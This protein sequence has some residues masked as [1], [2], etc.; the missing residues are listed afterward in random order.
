M[1]G[2][3]NL[4]CFAQGCFSVSVL[5]C[6]GFFPKEIY[7]QKSPRKCA[8]GDRTLPLGEVSQRKLGGQ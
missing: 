2:I 6:F 3:Y 7:A 5:F 8:S 1:I 4:N